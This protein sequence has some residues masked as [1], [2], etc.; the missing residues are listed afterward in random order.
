V[1][2]EFPLVI[3]YAFR[4]PSMIIIVTDGFRKECMLLTKNSLSNF[5]RHNFSLK[6]KQ[7]PRH[8]E[9]PQLKHTSILLV[10]IAILGAT[11]GVIIS[12]LL[13]C[14]K[15]FRRVS[16]MDRVVYKLKKGSLGNL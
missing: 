4:S 14:S 15:E 3:L 8:S 7:Q 12:S 16:I 5:A 9:I 1:N 10:Y 6:P 11:S 13:R 2:P